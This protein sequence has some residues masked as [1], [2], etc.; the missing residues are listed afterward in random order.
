MSMSRIDTLI[1][2]ANLGFNVANFSQ[3]RG[4]RNQAE[5][6]ALQQELLQ[7]L[8][9]AIFN[10]K[11]AAAQLEKEKPIAQAAALS[12]LL[13]ETSVYH[14]SPDLFP[15]FHDKE[16]VQTVLDTVSKQHIRVIN[17]LNDC[18]RGIVNN[19][20]TKYSTLP[21]I[22]YYVKAFP[23]LK[24]RQVAEREYVKAEKRLLVL[25]VPTCLS[26][27]LSVGC[28]YSSSLAPVWTA[29]FG[30]LFGVSFITLLIMLICRGVDSHSKSLAMQQYG[31]FTDVQRYNAADIRYKSNISMA[32]Q[33]LNVAKDFTGKVLSGFYD[34]HNLS[35][36]A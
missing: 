5:N 17:S 1:N 30:A 16:Y 23:H 4:I 29:I 19:F 24:K 32:T 25:I 33:E 12:V 2:V 10:F 34:D 28:Y 35:S 18:G 26:L 27:S 9:T 13:R 11:Q 22:E 20:M 31:V 36:S 3:L 21:T 6:Q 14:I 15:D 7:Q 8:R